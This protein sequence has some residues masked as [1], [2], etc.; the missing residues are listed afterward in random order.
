MADVEVRFTRRQE[1]SLGC[2]GRWAHLPPPYRLLLFPALRALSSCRRGGVACRAQHAGAWGYNE[3]SERLAPTRA[4]GSRAAAVL[5]R[6]SHPCPP[7]SGCACGRLR[8]DREGAGPGLGGARRSL[9]A[10]DLGA[11]PARASRPVPPRFSPARLPLWGVLVVR[12]RAAPNSPSADGGAHR[13]ERPRGGS[14][15]QTQLL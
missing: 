2:E 4:A 8:R 9:R 1:Q 14:P 6:L 11:L 10:L 5:T 3:D 13:R 15:V 12:V 7:S